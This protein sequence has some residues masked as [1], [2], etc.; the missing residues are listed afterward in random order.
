MREKKEISRDRGKEC[1]KRKINGTAVLVPVVI[2]SSLP[3]PVHI[4]S[5]FR[6]FR[7]TLPMLKTS[8]WLR[9]HFPFCWPLSAVIITLTSLYDR[10]PRARG[11]FW[12]I[13]TSRAEKPILPSPCW[14][15]LS[16][17]TR[18]DLTATVFFHLLHLHWFLL[19]HRPFSFLLSIVPLLIVMCQGVGIHGFHYGERA[20]VSECCWI[21]RKRL[22]VLQ[23]LRSCRGLQTSL[24][25][26]QVPPLCGG[27]RYFTG[28]WCG[29]G[30][31]KVWEVNEATEN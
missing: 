20:S 18:S 5:V 9:L 22:V 14:S 10:I 21:L 4:W 11:C 29:L 8:R 7:G 28:G 6:S 30:K 26:S 1:K 3:R 25:L 19:V 12:P 31:V 2:A 15:L 16:P 24:Q 13:F 27:H 17:T 23:P